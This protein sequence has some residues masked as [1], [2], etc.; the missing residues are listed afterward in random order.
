MTRNG[1]RVA[2]L[3]VLPKCVLFALSA[4]HAAVPAAM[5]EESL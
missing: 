2:R 4:Q 1:F 5:P 3:R